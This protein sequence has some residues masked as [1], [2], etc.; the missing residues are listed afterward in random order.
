ML[1]NLVLSSTVV[2]EAFLN[3]GGDIGLAMTRCVAMFWKQAV[4]F[5]MRESPCVTFGGLNKYCICPPVVHIFALL[6]HVPGKA[7][8][9]DVAVRL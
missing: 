1:G 9:S 3:S 7:E 6:L 2:S 5:L 4:A 8:R